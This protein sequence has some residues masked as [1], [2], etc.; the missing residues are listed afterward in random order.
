M[1]IWIFVRLDVRRKAPSNE[2]NN[3]FMLFGRRKTFGH[4]NKYL[5]MIVNNS[6]EIHG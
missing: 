4:L 6:L 1:G 2:L 3:M 5:G